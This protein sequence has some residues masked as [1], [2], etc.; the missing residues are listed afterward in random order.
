MPKD[1]EMSRVKKRQTKNGK[2]KKSSKPPKKNK[3]PLW[4]KLLYGFLIL[5]AVGLLAGGG[6][7]AYYA[8][9]AP[10]ITE[11]DLTGTFPSVVLEQNGEE[12]YNFGSQNRE[13]VS[14]D[15]V[16]EVLED[17]ILAIEDQRFY[18][19]IGVDPIRIAG[20]V[21]A[22]IT[23]GFG[24]EGGSTITQQ[25][26][27]LSVFSTKEEDQTLE[28]KAQEAWLAIQLE[29]EYSKEQ[30]L[31]LYINKVYM[32]DNVYGMGTAS[33][34]YY[35]KPISEL[36]LHEAALIAGMP[37]SPNGYNPYTNP[38]R[39]K[40]RRD[41]VLYMMSE[42]E[43]ITPEEAQAAMDIP[44]TEGLV[45]HSGEET[46]NLV[47]D[48]YIKQVLKEVQEKTG[49]DPFTSGLTIHTN[50][51]MDAQQ[52]LYDILNSDEYV[53]FPDE[54][55][56]AGVSM[57]DVETGQIKALGGGRNQEAQLG[58]NRATE[59]NRSIGS[60]MKPLTV[61]GPAIEQL[62]YSTYHQV[63]DEPYEYPTG[64]SVSNYDNRYRGQISM[65]EALVDSRN[66]PT[67][68]IFED[69]GLEQ[70]ENFI[71][72]LGIENMNN[73]DGLYWS[74]GI[75]GEVTPM[76]LSASY[77]AFANG[78]NYTEP[79]AVSK[80]VMRNG[81]EIDL[82]PE[83][84]R[85]MSDYTS[86]MITDMLKDVI[87]YYGNTLEIP[88]LPHAGKTGTTNYDQ[89]QREE[90]NIPSGAVP[91]SWFSGYSSNY[92]ISVWVGYDRQL[93]EGNWLSFDNGTRQLPRHIY[94][95]LM[96]YVSQSVEN[97]D[98]SRPSSVVEVA[99]EDG[100]MPA[101]LPG[102]NTPD[103]EIVTEL[104]VQGTEPSERSTA[105]GEELTAPTGLSASY[106]EAAD[107]VQIE[108]DA[109]TLQNED[110][111]P[112]Y[113]L[114][115]GNETVSVEGTE[116]VH[117]SP[118]AGEE[119]TITLAVQAYGHTGPSA[120]TT[121][122]I[123]GE[124]AEEDSEEQPEEDADTADTSDT[125]DTS[126]DTSEDTTDTSSEEDTS[127]EED[128]TEDT[129]D[130]TEENNEN[131]NN[132]DGDT[133]NQGNGNEEESEED[134]SSSVSSETEPDTTDTSG[135]TESTNNSNEDAAT[136]SGD[137]NRSSASSQTSNN[138]QE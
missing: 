111:T 30:I 3:R 67:M 110:E 92:S 4:K 9:S 47:F 89:Q 1:N 61:Y 56:Q 95:E 115:I 106:D 99:V 85:A 66:V 117:S 120:S 134:T 7:F 33:E 48:A 116:Y 10:E 46:N 29:Q 94:R 17:A 44:I 43:A 127:G 40:N 23:D 82:T 122:T 128:T 52:R 36:E 50:I 80:V 133:S 91:D 135:K 58:L 20:A 118:T 45:D 98:W 124:G 55:I 63:V 136:N 25:L 84:N 75:G 8:S 123:P 72:K 114:T 64:G 109:Y 77:A 97:S 78:G 5:I 93:E 69:V 113:Q 14:A 2:R 19:H 35:G 21:V 73:G 28:R 76:Q 132:D 74:N 68:K 62:N 96:S 49:L 104:F 16:P 138:E 37:Q 81:Q 41:T 59:L 70:A 121:V 6:L 18:S 126:E 119:L 34:Y 51:D 112:S 102:P 54:E 105:F 27:K 125:T 42:Y 38:E 24:S 130:T 71:S 53:S 137:Q 100:S 22:N 15:E 57:V 32:S 108:W 86:Y 103:S 39:A 79:Y 60:T 13:S 131:E 26:V 87:D 101:A 107:Q 11:E 90:L 129:A 88:G 83:T 31:T 65:R 12:F